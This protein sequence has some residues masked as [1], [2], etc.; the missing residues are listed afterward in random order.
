M[1]L[2]ACGVAGVAAEAVGRL[3]FATGGDDSG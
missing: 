2:A 1:S 3:G